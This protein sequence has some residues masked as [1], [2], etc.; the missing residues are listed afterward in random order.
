[1][2]NVTAFRFGMQADYVGRTVL[3][4][5]LHDWRLL[6]ELGVLRAIYLLGSG[7][8]GSLFQIFVHVNI[9]IHLSLIGL[10]SCYMQVICCNTSCQLYSIS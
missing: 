1:M 8:S 7:I 10:E 6:D 5:L 3:S 9:F 2:Y 4:K